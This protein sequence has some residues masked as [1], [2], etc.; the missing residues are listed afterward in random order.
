M[1]VKVYGCSLFGLCGLQ[2]T[3]EVNVSRGAK[4]YMV[5]LP[6]NAI[7]ESHQRISAA[8]KNI[9]MKI[10]IK[11]IIINLAPADVKK[12]GSAYDLTI[13]IALLSA[14]EQIPIN[15]IISDYLI[16]G[17]LSL[18]GFLRP[19]KG[20]LS[21]AILAKRNGF[22]GIVVPDENA[23]E[24]SLVEGIEVLPI[25]HIKDLIN[26]IKGIKRINA[27]VSSMK[28]YSPKDL[29][30][31]KDVK[32]QKSVKR[33]LE[34][35][36]AGGHNILLIG[37]PGSGKSMLAKRISSILPD[38]TN[39]E[40][41]ETTQIYS[42]SNL[43]NTNYIGHPPFRSPH[44]TISDVGMVGGGKVPKPGEIS[45]AHNGVLFLDEV[46]EFKKNVLEVLRQPL[47]DKEITI[48]RALNSVKFPANLML[49]GAMNPS[50]SG[51]F[52]HPDNSN[53]KLKSIKKYLSK[54]SG[55]FMDRIDLHIEVNPV[56]VNEFSNEAFEESSKEIRKRVVKARSFQYSRSG[57]K[58]SDLNEKDMLK[59]CELSN[60]SKKM[61]ELASKK[62]NI[63]A[64][65]YRRI[66][67][68]ARTIADLDNSESIMQKHIAEAI[69]YRTLD[70]MSQFLN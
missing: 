7:K 12:E 54:L 39:Q 32:G 58:N 62:M 46:P 36:A 61:L 56:P 11:E 3:V 33:A 6:D 16:M 55:P 49:V 5:G 10:P 42:I 1:M 53:N 38:L 34:I 63:S 4:F 65:S 23:N 18:D 8:L 70:R 29:L 59:H 52:Y 37:P 27:I 26:H 14:T 28:K 13:A 35:A 57:I 48:S 24:A 17:E 19:V 66:Q 22:K 51:D 30:D 60:E 47:E 20:V 9:G 25:N 50:P 69:Q 67:K 2:V 45:L 31:F 44:H 40:I 64:R 68:I 43:L 21:M 15:E 41:L